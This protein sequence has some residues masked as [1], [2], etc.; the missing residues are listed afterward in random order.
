MAG[1]VYNH[2]RLASGGQSTFRISKN[3]ANLPNLDKRRNSAGFL[4][5][6]FSTVHIWGYNYNFYSPPPPLAAGTGGGST[7]PTEGQLTP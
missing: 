7:R 5:W 3:R 6:G 2:L 4:R 1:I